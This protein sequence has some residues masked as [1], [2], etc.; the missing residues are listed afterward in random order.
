MANNFL[1]SQYVIVPPVRGK[2]PQPTNV[3]PC[4]TKTGR[5]HT[6]HTGLF[7]SIKTLSRKPGSP[8]IS[9]NMT[10]KTIISVKGSLSANHPI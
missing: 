7:I 9:Y 6:H 5:T 4:F 1:K 8:Y 10:A 2:N 3:T